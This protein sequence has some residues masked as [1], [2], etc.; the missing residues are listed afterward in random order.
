MRRNICLILT[1]SLFSTCAFAQAIQYVESRKVWL[2]TTR[3]NSYA[4]G[5]AANGE[6]EHLYWGAHCG[7]PTTFP[8]PVRVA[9][10]RRST[11]ARCSRTKSTPAGA[12][13]AITSPR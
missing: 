13:L 5:V 4:M 12:G 7:A 9:T 1:L 10:S 8:L 2:L 11:R 3:Q 6:L